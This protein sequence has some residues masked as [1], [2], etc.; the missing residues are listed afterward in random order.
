MKKLISQHTPAELQ[1]Y[2]ESVKTAISVRDGTPVYNASI[3]HA[4]I[5]VGEMFAH[6]REDIRLFTGRFNEAV[7]GTP[8]VRE[9]AMAFLSDPTHKVHILIEDEVEDRALRQHPF[10]QESG[11]QVNLEVRRLKRGVYD[12]NFHMML[13]DGESY[14]FEPNKDQPEAVATF[15]DKKTTGHLVDI[16]DK[17]WREG[18]A[19][20]I[21]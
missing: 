18:V 11:N 14:R 7:Y 12:T 3:D 9:Q 6:A 5:I 15:G 21:A 10:F 4:A 1:R 8:Q 19:A 17:L 16:F 20:T 13:M 2:R